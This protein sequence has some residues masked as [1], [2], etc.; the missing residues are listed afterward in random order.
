MASKLFEIDC[1][2]DEPV[3][4]ER[5]DDGELIFHGWDLETELAAQELG[6]QPSLCYDVW[7]A[8]QEDRLNQVVDIEAVAAEPKFEARSVPRIAAF[9]A[10]GA[11]PN[12]EGAGAFKDAARRGMPDLL[13]V[14]IAAGVRQKYIDR[15]LWLAAKHGKNEAVKVLLRSGADVNTNNGKALYMAAEKG[16]TET[17]RILLECG[18]DI[19]LAPYV[20]VTARQIAS[21]MG[22]TDIVKMILELEP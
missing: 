11:D 21:R 12:Y 15:A 5:R 20:A 17:V 14:Y 13:Q 16:K 22:H 2:D 9:L 18:A 3:V 10:A 8:K 7:K 1:G 6:F 4:M 19:Y